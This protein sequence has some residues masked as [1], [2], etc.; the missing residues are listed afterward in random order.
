M[1]KTEDA[2][3]S[4]VIVTILFIS[5]INE[6]EVVTVIGC[7]MMAFIKHTVWKEHEDRKRLNLFYWV[8]YLGIGIGYML[9]YVY[10]GAIA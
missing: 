1:S 2:I 6:I 5:L 7:F 3:W 8:S 9:I 10:F 4:I